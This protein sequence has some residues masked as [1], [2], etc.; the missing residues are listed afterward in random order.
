MVK[1]QHLD[2]VTF[3]WECILPRGSPATGWL[4]QIVNETT[5]ALHAADLDMLVHVS[6]GSPGSLFPNSR[7]YNGRLVDGVADTQRIPPPSGYAWPVPHWPIAYEEV[8]GH[9]I[10]DG[11]SK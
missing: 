2:G 10:A 6:V 7:F 11:S 9:E 1:A 8:D 3:D 4:V 5:T